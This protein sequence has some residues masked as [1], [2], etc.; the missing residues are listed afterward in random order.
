M[1]GSDGEPDYRCSIADV[2]TCGT[3]HR[4]D[5]TGLS[6]IM[7]TIE[8]PGEGRYKDVDDK[9]LAF[10]QNMPGVK[11]ISNFE[12][13]RDFWWEK[14]SHC[15]TIAMRDYFQYWKANGMTSESGKM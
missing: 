12:A 8:Q 5:A 9:S 4:D 1:D 15:S 2:K 3:F 13:V 7:G 11:V 14:T 10:Y 6:L